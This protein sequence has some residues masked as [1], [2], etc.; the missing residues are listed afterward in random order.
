[1]PKPVCVKCQRFFRHKHNG[2][3]VL[4]QRP[5]KT[6]AEPGRRS[7]GYWTHYKLWQ[8]DLMECPDCGAE[9]IVGFGRAPIAEYH[10]GSFLGLVK[11]SNAR[12][13]LYQVND[14]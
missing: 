7:M 2:V 9:I 1:M 11:A 5:T 14:Q 8:A 12:R 3:E 6:G 13:N 10:E 4:E